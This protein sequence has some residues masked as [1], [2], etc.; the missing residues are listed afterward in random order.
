MM[1]ISNAEKFPPKST[2]PRCSWAE[3][4]D[5]DMRRYHDCEWG[6]PLRDDRALFELLSLELMQSGLS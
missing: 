1:D 2:L 3:T 4:K 6:K 5:L